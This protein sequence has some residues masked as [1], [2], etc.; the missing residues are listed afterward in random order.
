MS[1]SCHHNPGILDFL[2]RFTG[3]ID[4]LLKFEIIG[5]KKKGRRVGDRRVEESGEGLCVCMCNMKSLFDY[6]CDSHLTNS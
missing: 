5:K 3:R 1:L 4:Y 6:W 2:L